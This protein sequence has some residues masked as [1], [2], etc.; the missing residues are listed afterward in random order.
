MKKE[1]FFIQLNMTTLLHE[2]LINVSDS[3]ERDSQLNLFGLLE[4]LTRYVI[5]IRLKFFLQTW[6][7][8]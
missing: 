2:T 8:I 1:H 5:L 4:S 7:S 3:Y 6:K